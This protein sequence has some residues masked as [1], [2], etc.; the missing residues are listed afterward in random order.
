MNTIWQ[1]TPWLPRGIGMERMVEHCAFAN[2]EEM[3]QARVDADK[4]APDNFPIAQLKLTL[5]D[6]SV[7]CFYEQSYVV[8][9]QDLRDAMALGPQDVQYLPVDAS[10]SVPL[11]RS[12]NYMIMRV[13]IVEDVSDV[14]RSDYTSVSTPGSSRDLISAR[15]VAIRQDANPNHEIFRDRFF[16]GHLLCSERFAAKVLRSGCTGVR[17]LDLN[18][19]SL[20][21]PKRFRTLRGI[22]EESWDYAKDE[23]CAKLIQ[24]IP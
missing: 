22:E 20:T 19:F 11:P 15:E 18:Y 6:F 5:E 4:W 14:D 24:S 10:L 9:S 17:F 8:V 3:F 16:L 21:K 13:P 7:D 2:D 1:F 12:K 23:P